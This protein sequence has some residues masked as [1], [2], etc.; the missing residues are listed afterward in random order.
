MVKV[1]FK[2]PTD[3]QIWLE[4]DEHLATFPEAFKKIGRLPD[5]QVLFDEKK[6]FYKATEF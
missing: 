5:R 3:T 4:V 2:M 6:A 1:K